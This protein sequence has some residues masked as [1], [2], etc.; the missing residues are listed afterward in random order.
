MPKLAPLVLVVFLSACGSGGAGQTETV[1]VATETVVETLTTTEAASAPLATPTFKLPS[2]NIGCAS[3]EGVLV[4]D[5][6]SGLKPEPSGQCELDWVGLE[7]EVQGP[8]QPRCAGDTSF[9][10]AAPVLDYGETWASGG[11]AC[12]ST[13]A[14]LECRN[15]DGRGFSLAR[16]A[17]TTA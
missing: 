1:I 4:C 6:L 15:R 2:G 9:D 13:K 11:I 14:G 8:A 7:L 3:S 16:T 10:Q 17:W 5:I 12:S